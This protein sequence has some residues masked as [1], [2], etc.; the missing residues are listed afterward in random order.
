M[1]NGSFLL[2]AH[3]LLRWLVLLSVAGAALVSW[4]GLVLKTPIMVWERTL[5]IV[6]LAVCHLQLLLGLLLYMINYKAIDIGYAGDTK[7]YWK[8]EHLGMMLIAILLVTLGRVLSKR[9]KA[10]GAKQLLVA[11]FYTAAL[12]IMLWSIPW[13]FT[14]L[15]WNRGW[16]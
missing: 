2:F 11:V 15:G 9:A 6:A 1:E 13:P 3:S 7:R 12:L 5:A 14:E 10:E 16:L 4:R 8:F